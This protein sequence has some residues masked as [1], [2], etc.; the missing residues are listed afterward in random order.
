MLEKITNLIEKHILLL[1]NN[2]KGNLNSIYDFKVYNNIF[3]EDIELFKNISKESSVVLDF[4]CGRG[5][6][7]YILS[8]LGFKV[9]GLDVHYDFLSQKLTSYVLPEKKQLPIWEKTRDLCT[10]KSLDFVFYDGI[11]I[12][13]SACSFDSIFAYAV[14]EHVDDLENVLLELNRVLKKEGFL[15]ISRTPNKYSYLEKAARYLKIPSHKVTLSKKEFIVALNKSGFE[16]EKIELI[17]FFP[18]NIP[19]KNFNSIYQSLHSIIR[20]LELV[21]R[22]LPINIF[23][24]HFRIIARKKK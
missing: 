18:S 3:V 16:I 4:G 9:T 21:I 15:F 17:D 2:Y 10:N 7:S 1:R 11:K 19:G 14:L 12:P 6:A 23:S 24:H 20:L 13:F 5:T 8:E 22:L